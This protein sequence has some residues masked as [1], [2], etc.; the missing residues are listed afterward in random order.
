[1]IK[2][3]TRLQSQVCD[4]QVIVVR[5]AD[6][7]D[8]LRAGGVPMVA[9]DAEKSSDAALDP[10]FADGNAMG[11]RYVDDNGAEV[12]VTKAGKGTLSVGTTPLSLKEAKPLPASD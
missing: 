11:K 1:M 5:S 10:A 7:L 6:S 2:N 4:T 12:L 8:D 9:L 3:G